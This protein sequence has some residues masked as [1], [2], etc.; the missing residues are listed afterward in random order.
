MSI[1]SMS[2]S[3]PRPWAREHNVEARPWARE[4]NVEA[5]PWAREHNEEAPVYALVGQRSKR[6]FVHKTSATNSKY[7]AVGM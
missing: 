4:H 6:S 1:A 5:R 7:E 2:A 3:S